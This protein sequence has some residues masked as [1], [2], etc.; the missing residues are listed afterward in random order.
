MRKLIPAAIVAAAVLVSA[1]PVSAADTI[2]PPPVR[3]TCL[4]VP[5][6]R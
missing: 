3:C 1:G 5:R 6:L 4:P 2:P